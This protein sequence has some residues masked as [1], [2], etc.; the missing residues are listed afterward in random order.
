MKKIIYDISKQ[1]VEA[2]AVSRIIT[3]CADFQKSS[4]DLIS[5]LQDGVKGG[6]NSVHNT[7]YHDEAVNID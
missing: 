3:Y 2:E 1:F 6:D 4:I 5:P 7:F